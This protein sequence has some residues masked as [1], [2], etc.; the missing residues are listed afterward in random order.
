MA[1]T[2]LIC[3]QVRI[4]NVSVGYKDEGMIYAASL[5]DG[6]KESKKAQD[7]IDED[8][9]IIEEHLIKMKNAG[10]DFL[11]VGAAGNS[12]NKTY[13][14]TNGKYG[15]TKSSDNTSPVFNVDAKYG[16]YLGAIKSES[17]KRRIWIYYYVYYA[18]LRCS[19]RNRR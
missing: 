14:K 1:Y 17:I 11:I 8:A 6:S 13:S 2:K 9:R 15:Y 18:R 5:N 12:N 4:I 3:N 7:F 16:Y 19:C 10:Y